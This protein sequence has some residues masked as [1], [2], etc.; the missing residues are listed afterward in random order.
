MKRIFC[1]VAA[2]AFFGFSYSYGQQAARE[3]PDYTLVPHYS[4]RINYNTTTV[5]IFP[6]AVRPIDRGDRDIIAQKQPGVENV[7]KLKAARLNF[8]LTNLHV[9]TADG[10]L[11]AFDITYFDGPATTRDLSRLLLP[12]SGNA[13]DPLILLSGEPV[14]TDQMNEYVRKVKQLHGSHVLSAHRDRMTV[15]LENIGLAENL[16]FFR[17]SIVNR[18]NLDYAIDFTRLYIRDREKAKRSSVQEKE[19]LPVYQD[20]AGTIVGKS[21]ITRVI[22][23]PAFTLADNKQCRI[24]IYEK[25]GGRSLTLRIKNR[26]LFNVKKL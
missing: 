8:P 18:S 21:S 24:E 1:L 20:T 12:T 16:L 17:L 7:L 14:N 4:L 26:H 9:F 5:L 22:A 15:R 2:F 23:V 6:S 11:Y 19:I 3:L 25:N 13:T 10:R